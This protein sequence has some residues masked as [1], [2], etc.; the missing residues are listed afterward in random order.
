MQ[1]DHRGNPQLEGH[2]NQ[3]EDYPTFETTVPSKCVVRAQCCQESDD[4]G[5]ITTHGDRF[6]YYRVHM[7]RPTY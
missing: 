1:L 5:A 3:V 4:I 7:L 6:T 2:E